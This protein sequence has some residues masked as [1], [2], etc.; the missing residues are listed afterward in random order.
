MNIERGL[1]LSGESMGPDGDGTVGRILSYR[2]HAFFTSRERSA[3]RTVVG[4]TET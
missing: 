1:V 2:A 3:P 4:R